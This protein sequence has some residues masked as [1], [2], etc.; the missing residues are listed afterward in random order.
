MTTVNI[1]VAKASLSELIRRVLRGEEVVIARANAPL[2]KLVSAK[3]PDEKRS[4]GWAEGRI[5]LADDFD[6]IP[7]DLADYA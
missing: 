5:E 4:L 1:H 3:R 2:V 7:P 6:E